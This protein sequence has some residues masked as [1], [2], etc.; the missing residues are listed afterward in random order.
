MFELRSQKLIKRH[1]PVFCWFD[2]FFSPP[3]L[4]QNKAKYKNAAIFMG[5]AAFWFSIY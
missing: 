4:G 3:G 1:I 5:N 2:L